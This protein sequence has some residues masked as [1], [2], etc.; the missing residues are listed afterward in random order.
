MRECADQARG[1][2]LTPTTSH[3]APRAV[4]A[5]TAPRE[6]QQVDAEDWPA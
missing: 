4:Q 1:V 3:L 2:S 6:G 5:M